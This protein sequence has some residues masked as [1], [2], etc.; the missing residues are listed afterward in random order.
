MD[1]AKTIENLKK[2]EFEVSYFESACEAAIYLDT[3]IDGKTVGFGDSETLAY[4]GMADLLK[5]HNTVY[6]VGGIKDDEEFVETAKKAMNTDVF[7]LSVNGISETG[8]MVNI[9]GTGNRVAGSLFGHDAVYFVAGV[10]KIRPTIEEAID[11]ARNIAAP[12]DTARFGYKTPCAIKSK[13]YDCHSPR[14]ICNVLTIYMQKM[15]NVD[16]VEVVL[17]NEELGF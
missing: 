1:I 7:M 17:I 16:H 4:M 6:D 5:H 14:R 8:A 3:K 9:D 10:N 15:N 13:C 11:R 2:N 12:L